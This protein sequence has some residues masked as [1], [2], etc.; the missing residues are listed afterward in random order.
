VL[1]YV[2]NGNQSNSAT[3]IQLV[4]LEPAGGTPTT[5]ST[6]NAVN[7]CASNQ[8]TGETICTANNTDIYRIRGTTITSTLTSASDVPFP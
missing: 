7:S 2:P 6:P 1:S 5:I 4:Q 3:G 8:A